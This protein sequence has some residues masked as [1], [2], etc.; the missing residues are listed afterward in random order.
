MASKMTAAAALTSATV[1]IRAELQKC[2]REA[3]ELER[4]GVLPVGMIREAQLILMD[5]G[6]PK[7]VAFSILRTEALHAIAFSAEN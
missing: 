1:I 3:L 7:D 2:A 5:G 6:L 4:T